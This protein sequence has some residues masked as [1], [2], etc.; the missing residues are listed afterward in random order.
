ML[1]QGDKAPDFELKDQKGKTHKL[2][3]YK[4]KVVLYFY[5]KDDTPGCTKEACNFRDDFSEYKKRGI[6]I[7][8]ISADNPEKHSKFM[9]KYSLPFT[10]LSDPEK[11]TIKNYGAYGEKRFMGKTFLGIKRMTFLIEK[12]IIKKIYPKV[13]VSEHSKEILDFFS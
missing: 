7:L 2:S 13:D 6:T 1:K 5:P 8:G 12:G 9:E 10:L 3:D 11:E 4:G